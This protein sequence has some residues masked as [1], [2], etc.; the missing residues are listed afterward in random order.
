MLVQSLQ[1]DAGGRNSDSDSDFLERAIS[2]SSE[3][4]ELDYVDSLTAPV[5]EGDTPKNG[6]KA[7][8][9]NATGA[10]VAKPVV[11]QRKKGFS[12]LMST[13]FQGEIKPEDPENESYSSPTA[14]TRK[15]FVFGDDAKRSE[16]KDSKSEIL[17]SP[18]AGKYR[19]EKRRG[20]ES[21][22]SDSDP[23]SEDEQE[24]DGRRIKIVKPKTFG[25]K[26]HHNKH[27]HT[28]LP[29]AAI[30]E[31]DEALKQA[32]EL[33]MEE[34]KNLNRPASSCEKSADHCFEAV[35]NVFVDI[36]ESISARF[37]KCGRR[38]GR[39][40]ICCFRVYWEKKCAPCQTATC[41]FLFPCC[42]CCTHRRKGQL[43]SSVEWNAGSPSPKSSLESS[44]NNIDNFKHEEQAGQPL[45]AQSHHNSESEFLTMAKQ[46]RIMGE[47]GKLMSVDE[48]ELDDM[49]I[50]DPT[51]WARLEWGPPP[52]FT[53]F[54]YKLK[55]LLTFL[56]V[57]TNLSFGFSLAWP[58]SFQTFVG[59]FN[60]INIDQIIS[61]VGSPDCIDGWNYYNTYIMIASLPILAVALMACVWLV[62]YWLP[63]CR[64][65]RSGSQVRSRLKF[66]KLFLYFLF[67]IYPGISSAIVRLYICT[68]IDGQSYL[69]TDLRVQCYTSMHNFYSYG[70]MTLLLL[71]PIGIPLLFFFQLY[72]NRKT[73]HDPHRPQEQ[74]RLG[75][76][77]AGYTNS[78]WYHELIDTI[79]KLILTSLVGFV[80]VT[81][82]IKVAEV[83]AG[84][85]LI[86][87]L[88]TKP[89]A[90]SSDDKL[91]QLCQVGIL[92]ILVAADIFN[93]NS[94]AYS[95]TTD[96]LVTAA[97][98]G[99]IAIFFFVFVRQAVSFLYR[100]CKVSCK[101]ARS[102]YRDRLNEKQT[103]EEVQ[104]RLKLE[105]QRK[106]TK[107]KDQ[108]DVA[109]YDFDERSD[110][111][112][113]QSASEIS[114][115][116][117]NSAANAPELIP[118]EPARD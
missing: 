80:P 103:K 71:Y 52:H 111:Q 53:D 7:T 96:A 54:T 55:I 37:T 16:S 86:I 11:Q 15:V 82:Q 38:C 93:N 9:R 6:E 41:A 72:I 77:Y 46:V 94:D 99:L 14:K 51:V 50:E 100:K 104:K 118:N 114:E 57:I 67:V 76:L 34:E 31:E 18:K 42:F 27:H 39:I 33:M 44:L 36:C 68:D 45:S 113:S 26:A 43:A 106:K 84:L 98:I 13:T 28:R 3:E 60:F 73:L 49:A 21:S 85:Y 19:I 5:P 65:C 101:D 62:P 107:A 92:L 109:A 81:A 1:I 66:W 10:V 20:A 23:F 25:G 102:R 117:N 74:A 105:Q 17:K 24:G 40:F 69:L 48:L 56:Q 90:I 75:F 32:R 63:C 22:S 4:D 79:H 30:V 78:A 70:S 2:S 116:S 61:L 115:F 110:D 47:D 59:Y 95:E 64:C 97:L 58:D 12:G 35:A 29:A 8:G 108:A 112:Q 89:Y 87:L 88:V 91:A 83:V